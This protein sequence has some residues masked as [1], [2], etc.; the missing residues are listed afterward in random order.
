MVLEILKGLVS[1]DGKQWAETSPKKSP[2]TSQ[3]IPGMKKTAS[4]LFLLENIVPWVMRILTWNEKEGVG[5]DSI[6]V[7]DTHA[8]GETPAITAWQKLI[9]DP[10]AISA[11]L[12]H[13]HMWDADGAASLLKNQDAQLQQY[14]KKT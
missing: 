2:E 8:A 5:T 7:G 9:T 1:G 12:Q 10:A 6:P 3:E 14:P 4:W 13:I 11:D